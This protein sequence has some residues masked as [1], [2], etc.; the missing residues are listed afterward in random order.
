LFWVHKDFKYVSQN[1][2]NFTGFFLK[3][4]KNNRLFFKKTKKHLH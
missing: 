4:D 3:K 1:K 2:I